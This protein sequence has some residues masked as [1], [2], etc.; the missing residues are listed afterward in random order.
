MLNGNCNGVSIDR[1]SSLQVKNFGDYWLIDLDTK[2]NNLWSFWEKCTTFIGQVL[3]YGNQ[4]S[5]VYMYICNLFCNL[6]A[7]NLY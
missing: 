2:N 1:N 7:S 6:S 5:F 4:R 3:K